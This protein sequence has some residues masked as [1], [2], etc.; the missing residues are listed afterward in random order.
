LTPAF[1]VSDAVTLFD[2]QQK[3]NLG[4]VKIPKVLVPFISFIQLNMTIDSSTETGTQSYEY[5]LK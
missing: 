3:R 5:F 4:N 1:F 2:V